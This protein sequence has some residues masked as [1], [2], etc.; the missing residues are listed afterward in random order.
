MTQTHGIQNYTF[1]FL[2]EIKEIFMKLYGINIDNPRNIYTNFIDIINKK[3]V[4]YVIL[5]WDLI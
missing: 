4:Y 1:Q 5:K 3:M 2:D